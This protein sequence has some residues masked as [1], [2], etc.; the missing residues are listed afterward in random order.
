[1]SAVTIEEV[2]RR[3]AIA[4][5]VVRTA[6]REERSC[7]IRDAS[8]DDAAFVAAIYN[9]S[10]ALE[11]FISH[12]L[13]LGHH[14]ERGAPGRLP[15]RSRLVPFTVDTAKQWIDLH[16]EVRRSLWLACRDGTPVG[17]LSFVGQADRPGMSYT[18]ELAIYVAAHAR[19]SGVAT[20]LLSSALERAADMGLDRL[21]AM[22]WSDNEAS[23]R[24]FRKHGFVRW[25]RLPGVVW[26]QGV[27][28][29]M[30][31]LGRSFD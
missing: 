14:G 15:A 11:M 29:D 7:T 21:L 18:S 9:E 31:V 13:T 10:I 16:T 20:C 30:L 28:H 8:L 27:S 22:V 25:G 24:L 1:V 12:Q 23:L 3:T 5:A 19:E 6:V 26:A 4:R 2:W 17:F